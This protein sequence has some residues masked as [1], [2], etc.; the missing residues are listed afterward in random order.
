MGVT[1]HLIDWNIIGGNPG[2]PGEVTERLE[3]VR[4]E[5]IPDRRCQESVEEKSFT[6][7]TTSSSDTCICLRVQCVEK[8]TGDKVGRP[9]YNYPV[10]MS[11]I[12]HSE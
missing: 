8:C 12:L 10:S 3:E 1:K 7:N 5:N 11:T 2:N 4:R 6:A 9:D